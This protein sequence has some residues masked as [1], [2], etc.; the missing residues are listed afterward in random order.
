LMFTN[1]TYESLDNNA[2]LPLCAGKILKAGYTRI[3]IYEQERCNVVAVLHVKDLSFVEPSDK[4]SLRTL[5][6]FYNRPVN[7]V[8]EDTKLDV[9]LEEFKKG[10]SHMAFLQRVNSEGS[11]DPFYETLGMLTLEDVIEEIFQADYVEPSTHFAV[12]G[13]ESVALLNKTNLAVMTLC[14]QEKTEL[15]ISSQLAQAACHFLSQ[16]VEQFHPDLISERVLKRLLTDS[17]LVK[18]TQ[19]EASSRD[20]CFLYENGKPSDYF[21]LILEGHVE[22]VIGNDHLVFDGGPFTFLGVQALGDVSENL[23]A[24]STMNLLNDSSEQVNVRRSKF[25]PDFSARALSCVLYV[26]IT[27]SLYT[28]A[29]QATI[30]QR[31]INDVKT[32]PSQ[33]DDN[34]WQNLFRGYEDAPA[35]PYD[36]SV[37]SS[38]QVGL[39]D[40]DEELGVKWTNENMHTPNGSVHSDN[41]E[42]RHDP[43]DKII[44]P[45]VTK[46]S[47]A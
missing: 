5:C 19:E 24:D 47:T 37:R 8:F 35:P 9:M 17:S 7:F 11:G 45:N 22:I 31:Q 30:L 13:K 16:S 33:T 3:P 20:S 27:Q 40:K 42:S 23:H 46:H 36:P 26:R 43:N 18:I 39:L 4:T 10:Q 1:F 15:S 38:S 6:Q 34:S 12:E 25:V 32:D 14:N 21:A 2:I 44:F 28:A 41:T 29:R